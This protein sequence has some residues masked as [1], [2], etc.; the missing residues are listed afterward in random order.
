MAMLQVHIDAEKKQLFDEFCDHLGMSTDT[1]I[2]L[3]V[4]Q[5]LREQKIPFELTVLPEQNFKLK[6]SVQR[7]GAGVGILPPLPENFDEIF[8]AM[9]KE[10]EADFESDSDLI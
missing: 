4:N 8:D 9:D 10:I 7:I 6:G 2:C 3:F 1:A 5:T